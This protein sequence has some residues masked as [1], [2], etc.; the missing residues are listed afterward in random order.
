MKSLDLDTFNKI[1]LGV[2]NTCKQA[3][4]S[5]MQVHIL[6]GEGFIRETI[7]RFI[8]MSLDQSFICNLQSKDICPDS[9][10]RAVYNII[11]FLLRSIWPNIANQ[12]LP[13]G[14]LKIR[15]LK[16]IRSTASPILIDG[17][18]NVILKLKYNNPW[19]EDDRELFLEI[20]NKSKSVS[21]D[22]DSD[23]NVDSFSGASH[24]NIV[25]LDAKDFRNVV[26]RP[27]VVSDRDWSLIIDNPDVKTSSALLC[28]TAIQWFAI[29]FSTVIDN[30][31]L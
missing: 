2:A 1:L 3:I 4:D 20:L 25:R 8:S 15:A 10:P 6:G 12:S 16:E 13:W 14:G 5:N 24:I 27:S 26:L 30:L 23:I 21:H 28:S 17:I 31:Y 18:E 7:T 9:S 11:W 29:P 19:L 22:I